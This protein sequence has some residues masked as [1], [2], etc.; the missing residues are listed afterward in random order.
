MPEI[1]SGHNNIR[2]FSH[3][4]QLLKNLF[5]ANGVYFPGDGF[6]KLGIDFHVH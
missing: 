2:I 4:I 5:Q 3:D 1:V 6:M